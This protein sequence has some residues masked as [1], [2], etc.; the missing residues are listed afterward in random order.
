MT[1]IEQLGQKLR[2]IR[3]KQGMALISLAE[4][5]GIPK[6]N[7]SQIETGTKPISLSKMKELFNALGYD[8]KI[9]VKKMKI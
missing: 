9:V 5:C 4:K 3:K 8:F 7:L 1:E 6:Q 2:E